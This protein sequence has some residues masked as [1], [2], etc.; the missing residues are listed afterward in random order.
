LESH[1]D[2][3][4]FEQEAACRKVEGAETI[5]GPNVELVTLA[6]ARMIAGQLDHRDSELKLPRYILDIPPQEVDR[7]P[8]RVHGAV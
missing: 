4:L 1:Q 8:T 3:D 6:G 2:G 7:R 5:E